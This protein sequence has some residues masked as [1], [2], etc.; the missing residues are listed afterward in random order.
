MTMTATPAS[1]PPGTLGLPFLG[2]TGAPRRLAR[3]AA[4]KDNEPV[5]SQSSDLSRLAQCRRAR[6]RETSP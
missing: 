6:Q 2:E 4:G 5:S 3:Q 1:L